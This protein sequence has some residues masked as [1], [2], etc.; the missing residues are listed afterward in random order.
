MSHLFRGRWGV[1]LLGSVASTSAMAGEH[2]RFSVAPGLQIDAEIVASEKEGFRVQ[3]AQ[4]T[5]IIPFDLL[6]DMQDLPATDPLG[7][8][9]WTVVLVGEPAAVSFSRAAFA[10]MPE[11]R[12]LGVDEL[13]PTLRAESC[14]DSLPCLASLRPAG[15]W[16]A[17]VRARMDGSTLMLDGMPAWRRGESTWTVVPADALGVWQTA[18]AAIGLLP[19]D[20]VPAAYTDTFPDLLRDLRAVRQPPVPVDPE[21]EPGQ[22]TMRKVA[23]WSFIPVPGLPSL[24]QKDYGAFGGALASTAAVTAG[25]VGATGATSTRRGEHIALATVGSYVGCV[26]SNQLFG[27][28]GLRNGRAAV[29]VL[30]TLGDGQVDGAM[31]G[32]HISEGR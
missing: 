13:D 7:I 21:P 29:S 18:Q 10:A 3:I 24:L 27:A 23:A 19:D 4:G 8:T 22:W 5:M 31:V 25:W 30:P 15:A 9:P 16:W 1:L 17:L 12:V 11:T 6:E 14:A 26:A 32:L 20:Q 2:R 28:L